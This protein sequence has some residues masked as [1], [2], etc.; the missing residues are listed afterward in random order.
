MTSASTTSAPC[1]ACACVT[2]QRQRRS[3]GS[4]ALRARASPE[5]VGGRGGWR[6]GPVHRIAAANSTATRIHTAATAETRRGA[7]GAPRRML[8]YLRRTRS[9]MSNYTAKDITVLEGLEPVRK[10]PGMYIGGVGSDRPAPPGVG[11]PGQRGGRGD[12][13]PRLHHRRDPA[14]RRQLDHDRRRRPRHP[15]GQAPEDEEERARGDL[16]GAPRRREVRAGQLQDRRRPARRRRQRGQRAV[17]GAA[18]ARQA[19]RR[20]SGSCRSSAA[21]R[22]ARS[23]KWGRRGAAARPCTSGPIRPSSRRSSSIR[24]SSASGW[25]WS[26]TCTRASRSPSRTRRRRRSRPSSTRKAC[27]TT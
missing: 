19:R 7:T 4:A 15:G 26:A 14:R 2:D 10:R 22:R 12:E 21:R 18:R 5:V 25:R 6:P 23:R 16:H 17:R 27:S 9:S 13:R 24:R 1:D 3:S 8:R 20:A 11:D